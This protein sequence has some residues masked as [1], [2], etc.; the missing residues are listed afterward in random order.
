[1]ENQLLSNIETCNIC[2]QPR[3]LGIHLN[4]LFIC[5]GCEKAIVETDTDHPMYR[6]YIAQLKNMKII[7]HT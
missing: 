3:N 6:F 4:N 7:N 1:M 5:S 2:N